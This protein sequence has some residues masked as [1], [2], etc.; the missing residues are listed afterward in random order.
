[1]DNNLSIQKQ[2]KTKQNDK[3]NKMEKCPVNINRQITGKETILTSS[4]VRLLQIPMKNYYYCA[5]KV[6]K[7]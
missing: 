2:N 1:M 4:V 5:H 3:K 7:I 6:S